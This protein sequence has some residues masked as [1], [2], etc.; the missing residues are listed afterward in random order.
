MNRIFRNIALASFAFLVTV[1]VTA[2]DN[3]K[4]KTAGKGVKTPTDS[5][6][7]P[8]A[9]T[10]KGKDVD[11]QQ[12]VK[13]GKPVVT[14]NDTNSINWKEQYIESKGYSVMDKT[15][16][17]LEG[18]AEL[19][20]Y[21]GA[22]ADCWRNLG[23]IIQGVRVVGETT[24]EN[25]I[26][27]SDYVYTRID[28][29]IKN[30][31][32]VGDYKVK[33]NMVEVV[34]RIPLSR[35]NGKQGLTDVIYDANGKTFDTK[36]SP[37]TTPVTDKKTAKSGTTVDPSLLPVVVDDQGNVVF[38]YSKYYDPST[39]K[40]PQYIEVTKEVADILGAGSDV[41]NVINGV[42]DAA[43]G[44]IKI[45][46]GQNDKIDKWANIIGKILKIGSTIIAF[47]EYCTK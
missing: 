45:K 35:Q 11:V 10:G 29:F 20:A 19:M 14:G 43:T 23:A 4:D 13:E 18:Q 26:T 46:A 12:V 9:A 6:V 8:Q 16:Y 39:G 3:S 41:T 15:R 36:T 5:V 37:A 17:P 33:G 21:R 1:S 7:K 38:D 25:Y 27:T 31:E 30:A 40:I 42:Q 34:M 22:V 32:M 2:Q 24:V 28:A 44:Q 47:L